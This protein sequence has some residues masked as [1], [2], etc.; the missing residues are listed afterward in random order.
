MAY[1]FVKINIKTIIYDRDT[2][3]DI[4]IDN[5][6]NKVVLKTYTNITSNDEYDYLVTVTEYE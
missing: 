2:N 4:V 3:G 1:K 5:E 6:G